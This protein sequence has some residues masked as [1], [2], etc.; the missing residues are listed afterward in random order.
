MKTYEVEVHFY[1]S[2]TEK[3]LYKRYF[4]IME[5]SEQRAIAAVH[6]FHV[7][8]DYHNFKITGVKELSNVEV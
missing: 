6:N 4:E 8:M 7:L 3:E 5:E 1:A 2:G